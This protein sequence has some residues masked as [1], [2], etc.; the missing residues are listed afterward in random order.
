MAKKVVWILV[1]CLMVLSLVIAS[2]GPKEEEKAKVTEEEE[3]KVVI[4]E[5]ETGEKVEEKEEEGLLPPEVPKYGGI[6]TLTELLGASAFD[7][8]AVNHTMCGTVFITNEEL[9]SGDLSKGP[10]GTGE[11]D[12]FDGF[13]GQIKYVKGWL[14]ESWDLPDENTIIYNIRPGVKWWNKPPINGRELTA[15]DVVWS[16]NKFFTSPKSHIYN[17]FATVG[18]TPLSIKALDKYTVEIKLPPGMQGM[19]LICIGAN[20]YTFPE[21]ITEMVD[22]NDWRNAIGTGPWMLTD[23]VPSSSQ[24]FER[25]PNYWQMDPNHPENQLPYP[26]KFL[27]LSIPDASTQLAAFRTGQVDRLMTTWENTKLLMN[28]NPEIKYVEMQASG[29]AIHLRVDKPELPFYDVRVRQALNMAVNKQE[30]IDE[31]YEGKAVMLGYPI[32]THKA[33]KPMYIPLEELPE[34]VQEIFT[35]NPEKAK[36]LLN[37]AGYPDGFKIKVTCPSANADFLS[38]IKAY[39]SDI[40]VDMEIEPLE[41]STWMSFWTGRKHEQAIYATLKPEHPYMFYTEQKTQWWDCSFW[42]DPRIDEAYKEVR[43]VLGINDA[44]LIRIMRE[45]T[46]IILESAWGVWLPTPYTYTLYWPWFQGWHGEFDICYNDQGRDRTFVWI[47]Q[48]LKKSMGY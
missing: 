34:S 29:I 6:M 40:N 27:S 47:D 24:T 15:Q 45:S 12:Y 28:E 8:F 25:N 43:Q 2:C 42:S 14:A 19:W 36:E 32:K 33:F 21:N 3:G 48:A 23:L 16:L 38:L 9:V 39:F 17:L 46:P 4:T 11:N 41:A 1:S 13:A 20:M 22:L 30:I 7:P 5:Q 26:D 31:Y 35:Y 37:E 10:S 18:M 44:E